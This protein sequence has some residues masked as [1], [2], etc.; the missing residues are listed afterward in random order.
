MEA[1]FPDVE[2]SLEELIEEIT[3]SFP[4]SAR[5][6]VIMAAQIH[7]RSPRLAIEYW[8]RNQEENNRL[9]EAAREMMTN[10]EAM[11]LCEEMAAGHEMQERREGKKDVV[12]TK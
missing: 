4:A 7:M 3:R 6:P 9:A 12:G 5:N 2:M 1:D 8:A 11:A 10:E